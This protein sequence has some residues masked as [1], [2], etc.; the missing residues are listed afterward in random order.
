MG[1]VGGDEEHSALRAPEPIE[2]HH[3]C[4]GFQSGEPALDAWLKHRALKNQRI[5]ATRTYVACSENRVVGYYSLAVGSASRRIAT[6]TVARNMPDPVPVML[7]ARLAVHTSWQ[8]KGLGGSLL[9]DAVAR[10]LQAAGIAGIRAMLV[11]ALSE[12][13]KRFYRYFGFQPAQSEPMTLM[14]TLSS[15][16]RAIQ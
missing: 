16:K 6:G 1:G 9:Q 7:L 2:S 3:D 5:G 13:A 11:H 15:F 12:D 14:A 4:S 8:G 10:T